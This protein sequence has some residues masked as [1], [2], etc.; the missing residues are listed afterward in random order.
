M[1]TLRFIKALIEELWQVVVIIWN[2][3]VGII[4]LIWNGLLNK[5]KFKYNWKLLVEAIKGKS[6]Y[7]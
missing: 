6:H 3:P 1:K 7:E 2:L 4:E 5:E